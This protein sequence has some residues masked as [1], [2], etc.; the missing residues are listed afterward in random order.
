MPPRL[1]EQE[2]APTVLV[3]AGQPETRQRLV[4]LL[5]GSYRVERAAGDGL[6]LLGMLPHV[7]PD[8]M[9]VEWDLPRIGGLEIVLEAA[10]HSPGTQVILF[11][12]RDSLAI[13]RAGLS[14]G[15]AG[16]LFEPFDE[17]EL[18]D[19]L[20]RAQERRQVVSTGDRDS[21]VSGRGIWVFCAPS[22]GIGRTTLVLSAAAIL[23]AAGRSTIIFE[24]DPLFGDISFFLNLAPAG[25]NLAT[26]LSA[27]EKLDGS[28]V[29]RHLR[30]HE[31]GLRIV[32]PPF[33][34]S[35]YQDLAPERIL[36]AISAARHI[37][38]HVLVDIPAGYDPG[39]ADLLD[40]A[41]LVLCAG[42][43]EPQRLKNLARMVSILQGGGYGSLKLKKLLLQAKEPPSPRILEA[44][45]LELD[46]VL[47]PDRGAFRSALSGAM[48]LP[49]VAPE[50][51]YCLRLREVLHEFL[52]PS[53]DDSVPGLLCGLVPGKPQLESH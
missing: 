26:M 31:S 6:E 50:S 11:S 19:A 16:F 10:R 3:G 35:R 42:H 28:A 25:S 48:P 44:V 38:D 15:A 39:L 20:R 27:E 46:G 30:T 2:A 34:A 32:V 33:D 43:P 8:L 12:S 51:P 41:R 52:L 17:A 1:E 4:D 45:A 21:R 24:L 23:E 5:S 14:A 47:P 18:L 7:A 37:A 36:Q 40:R 9:L 49:L 13:L 29:T 53:G 22:G